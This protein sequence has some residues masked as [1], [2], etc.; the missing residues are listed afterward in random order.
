MKNKLF[1]LLIFFLSIPTFVALL[2]PGYFP[3]H[4][5]MQAMRLLQ[6]DKCIMDFQIPCRWVPD[7]G[8]GYGYPQFNFYSPLPYY[9]M[10]GV[11]LLG[12]GILDSVKVGFLITIFISAVGM[13]LLGEKLWGK[14]GGALSALLFVYAP[15]RA[16]DMY[17]RGAV[18]EFWALSILPWVFLGLLLVYEQK[19]Y[20]KLV[21]SL[22]LASLFMS[23]NVTV[24]ISLPFFAGFVILLSLQNYFKNKDKSKIFKFWLDGFLSSLWGFGIAS[25]F[26]LPAVFEQQYVHIE[27]LVGGYFDYRIHFVNIRQLLFDQ[28]WGYGGSDATAYDEIYL[29]AGIIHWVIAVISLGAL[30]YFRKLK[31]LS[32]AIFFVLLAFIALFMSHSK[33]S[34]IWSALS[35]LEIIQFPWRFLTLATF[36]FSLAAGSII[37][38]TK[39]KKILFSSIFI[40]LTIFYSSFFQPKLWLNITEA[41]KFSGENWRLQQTISIFDYLPKSA[42]LPPAERAPDNPQVI[43]GEAEVTFVEKRSYWSRF[44]VSVSENAI[45]QIPIYY[46]PGWTVYTDGSEIDFTYDNELGLL[47]IDLEEGDHQVVARL[48]D[49][50]V[51]RIGN[52]LSMI[53]VLGIG[54]YFYSKKR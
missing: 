39:S 31:K 52:W 41:E 11:H 26:L 47:T 19:K 46:F 8:Y 9:F 20:S 16:V 36:G 30:A 34:P 7:M 38:L 1:L 32:Y 37:S 35:F 21:L 27:T 53:S 2:R 24:L 50:P 22:S 10:E 12:V 49:T 17:V 25:F 15:Y 54:G 45:M 42:D 6:M 28:F 44:E 23:H 51:R 43:E 29:G 13:Y 18:G 3:M 14:W 48:E 5:D 33:S 4:D 40:L